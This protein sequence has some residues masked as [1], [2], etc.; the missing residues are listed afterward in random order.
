VRD[1]VILLTD[2]VI[3]AYV[4]ERGDLRGGEGVEDTDGEASGDIEERTQLRIEQNGFVV[5]TF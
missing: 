2:G 1:G 3:A 5:D 4:I